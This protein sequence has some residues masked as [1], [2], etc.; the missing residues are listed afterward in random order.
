MPVQLV[1]RRDMIWDIAHVADWQYIK[2]HKQMLINKNNT[3]END[4]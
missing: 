2:Q 4:K 1:F 3:K